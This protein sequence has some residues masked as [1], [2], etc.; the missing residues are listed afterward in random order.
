MTKYL[1]A[2][3]AAVLAGLG[4]AGTAYVSNDG[5]IGFVAGIF[6]A[7]ATVT[8]FGVVWGVPNSTPAPTTG[9]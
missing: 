1:K 6:I 4:A 9:K 3:Y 2:I 7:T 5:H 8:A